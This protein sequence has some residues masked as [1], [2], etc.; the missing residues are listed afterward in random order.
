M[1]N[2][3]NL[4]IT[5]LLLANIFLVSML[6]GSCNNNKPSP[7]TNEKPQKTIKKEMILKQV[8]GLEYKLT[9]ID[10]CEYIEAKQG[11]YGWVLTHKGN[12]RFCIRRN[13]N[14]N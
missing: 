9:I 14:I 6:F 3:N 11:M 4:I 10:H 5:C 13:K 8:Y 1:K 2:K 7:T 12:C